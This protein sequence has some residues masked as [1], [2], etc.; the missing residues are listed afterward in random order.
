[1]ECHIVLTDEIRTLSDKRALF[2][3]GNLLPES[4]ISRS[5]TFSSLLLDHKANNGFS[6]LMLLFIFSFMKNS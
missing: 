3:H 4:F 1:L 2:I 6:H 5:E